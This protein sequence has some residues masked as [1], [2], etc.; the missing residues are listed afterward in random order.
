M[1]PRKVKSLLLQTRFGEEFSDG[2]ELSEPILTQSGSGLTDNFFAFLADMNSDTVTG[3]LVRAGLRAEDGWLEYM[4]SCREAPFSVPPTDTLEAPS[5][6]FSP[7]DYARYASA[8]AR[9]REFAFQESCSDE[10]IAILESY[11]TALRRVVSSS[12]LGFHEEVA[13]SFFQWAS[14]QLGHDWKA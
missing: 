8:Y 12:L 3:P 10:E 9:L 1:V 2:M 7:A 5:P 11:L 13:P 6:D 4:I 14:A